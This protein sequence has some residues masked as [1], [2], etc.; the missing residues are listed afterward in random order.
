MNC[1]LARERMVD[2]WIAGVD[3]AQLFELNQ[4]VDG[5]ASCKAEYETLSALWNGLGEFPMEE[6]SV[7]L[8]ANFHQMMEA[9]RIGSANAAPPRKSAGFLEYLQGLW[10]RQAWQQF[11]V[12]AM[13]LVFGLVAGHLYTSRNHDLERIG[14]LSSEVQHMKQ[15]VALS[16]L[17]QQSA[18]ERLR[19][20]SYSV[21]MEADDEVL[22]AL[23][24]TLN[25][26]P[27]VNVRLAAVDALKQFGSR[28]R[29]K[30]GLRQAVLNQDSPLL[31]MALIDYALETNDR[32]FVDVFS[33]LDRTPDLH[34]LVKTR[35]EG[36]LSQLH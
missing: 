12:A 3:E 11:A 33:K 31:Q 23:L 6:P 29:V 9:Y 35:L 26:D 16:L 28:N 4:H 2:R 27:N 22:N 15:L 18:S 20:V 7:N 36:A 34:P 13:A 5:C 17:Q 30:Q 8:R 32:G 1:E 10:P 14:Q 24:R 21:R 19:G 25:H